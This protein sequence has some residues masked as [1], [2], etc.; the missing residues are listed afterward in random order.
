VAP[1]RAQEGSLFGDDLGLRW[2]HRVDRSVVGTE[3][4]VN[5]ERFTR[6]LGVHAP[7]RLEWDLGALA[8][9]GTTPVLRELSGCAGIDDSVHSTAARGS[10][11]FKVEVDG[12]SRWDSGVVR[13]GEPTRLLPRVDLR[14]AKQLALIVDAADDS[15]VAD[16]A[17]WLRLVLVREP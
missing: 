3:L 17:D 16:R 1:T 5:G 9:A 12:V 11:R 14:G 8:K 15:F 10:V 7:S 2:P 6:G 13:G 4:S